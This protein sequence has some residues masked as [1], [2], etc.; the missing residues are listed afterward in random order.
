MYRTIC[1]LCL[2]ISP[3]PAPTNQTEATEPTGLI[4]DHKRR[5]GI[6]FEIVRAGRAKYHPT[7]YRGLRNTG[8]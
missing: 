8:V 3:R 4:H 1:I 6:I 7:V 2:K 5:Y